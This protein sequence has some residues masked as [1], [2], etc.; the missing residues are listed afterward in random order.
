MSDSGNSTS[1]TAKVDVSKV[2]LL[3]VEWPAF[4]VI[5]IVTIAAMYL[6][7]LP[8][9]LAGQIPLLMVIGEAMRFIGDRIPIVKDYL[10]GGSVVVLLGCAALVMFGVIPASTA[11]AT[12][13][14]MNGVFVNFALAAL[15]C[16]SIFGMDRDLLLKSS[17]RYLPCIAGGV[18]VALLFAGIA[19]AVLGF[20]FADAILYI[21]LP[22]MGGGTAAGAVPMSQMFA[23]ALNQ[24]AGEL[25]GMMTPAVAFG[26]ALA[27]VSAGLLNK[28]G[29]AKPS[30][31]GNGNIL[32]VKGADLGAEK[33]KKME[34]ITNLGVFACGMAVAGLFLGLGQMIQKNFFPSIHAYAWM[35]LL[36]VIVKALGIMPKAIEESCSLWYQFFIKNFTNVLLAGLGIG[37]ISLAPIIEA[38]SFTYLILV[39]AVVFGAIVGAGVAGYFVGFYPI[40]AAITGGLCMANMGGSG[41]I[42]TLGAADRMDLMPFAAVSSRLGGALIL[43]LGSIILPLLA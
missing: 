28:L 17:L 42:A 8:A 22:I 29:K 26:N 24:D 21:G 6:G 12:K 3:G 40:E 35:I 37:M 14:F 11:E 31:T 2:K 30:L 27:I 38:F 23:D 9:S 1:G 39:A 25:L 15:C 7:F 19:G 5:F 36:M 33:D 18:I 32:R 16:G 10:G 13:E 41:D 43:I 20:G 34:P 4:L